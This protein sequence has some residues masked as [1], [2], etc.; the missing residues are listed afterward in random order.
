MGVGCA[1][2]QGVYLES[3]LSKKRSVHDM[4]KISNM[5]RNNEY[6]PTKSSLTTRFTFSP[7]KL[8]LRK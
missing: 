6:L 7:R 4:P 2:A 3:A 5:D 8:D 1:V